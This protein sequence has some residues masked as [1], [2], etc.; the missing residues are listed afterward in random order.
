M[1]VCHGIT[2]IFILTFHPLLLRIHIYGCEEC[3]AYHRAS[4]SL[5][6][7]ISPIII[8]ILLV[9]VNVGPSICLSL[10]V[11]LSVCSCECVSVFK[12]QCVSLGMCTWEI[13]YVSNVGIVCL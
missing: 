9:R 8:A 1:C 11:C 6:S 4:I 2:F 13:L 7:I 5:I 10:C 12:R 3:K